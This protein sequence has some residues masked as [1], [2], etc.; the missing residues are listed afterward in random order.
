MAY[1]LRTTFSR[2]TIVICTAVSAVAISVEFCVLIGV[3]LSFVLYVPRASRVDL[4][5][6]TLTPERVVRDVTADVPCGRHVFSLEELFF[7]A[8]R[9]WSNI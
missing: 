2:G 7:G 9:S 4:T 5:E 3:F 1:Y 6:L 8:L